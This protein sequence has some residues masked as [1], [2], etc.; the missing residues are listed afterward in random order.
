MK[1]LKKGIS[2]KNKVELDGVIRGTPRY[3]VNATSG[4]GCLNF[5]IDSLKY[6]GGE[7]RYFDME[8]VMFSPMCEQFKDVLKDG[9][10]IASEG[11][12]VQQSI[13]IG[14]GENARVIRTVKPCIDYCE[15]E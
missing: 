7:K 3:S 8:C 15:I 5:V 2:D 6:V 13:S 11:H 10:A 14:E 9:M 1:E 12:L 4:K